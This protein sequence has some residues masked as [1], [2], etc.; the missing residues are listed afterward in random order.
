MPR[1]ARVV[2]TGFPHHLTQRGNRRQ[3]TFFCDEDFGASGDDMTTH[4]I[5]NVDLDAARRLFEFER[6]PPL[7]R[8]AEPEEAWDHQLQERYRRVRQSILGEVP[9]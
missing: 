7:F 2:A 1:I 4:Y 5:V 9:E 6:L 3:R 8:E